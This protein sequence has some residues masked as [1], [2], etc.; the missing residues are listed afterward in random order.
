V[1]VSRWLVTSLIIFS[2]VG[3][4]SAKAATIYAHTSQALAGNWVM[5]VIPEPQ[6]LILVGTAFIGLAAIGR[7]L[8]KPDAD[9]TSSANVPN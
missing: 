7:R 6:S 9:S 8:R 4:F 2:S 1:K 3:F 5:P